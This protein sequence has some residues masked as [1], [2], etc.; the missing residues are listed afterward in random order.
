M[1]SEECVCPCCKKRFENQPDCCPNCLYPFAGSEK[2]KSKFIAHYILKKREAS[3]TKEAQSNKRMIRVILVV[4]SLLI[5][6][7]IRFLGQ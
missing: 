7:I 4:I 1:E 3:N 6:L 2:V 5:S